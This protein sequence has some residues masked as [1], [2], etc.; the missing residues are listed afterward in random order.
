MD[1]NQL[2][3]LVAVAREKSFSRAAEALGR[4]QPAVSQAIQ[5][6]EQETGE[7]LFD[8]SSK[9]GTL[10]YAGELL[11]DYARQMLNVRNAAQNA[12]RD[13]R[14]LHSGRLTISANEHT[15]FGVLPIISELRKRHPQLKVEVQRGVASRIPKEITA[16]EV[17]L[18]VVSFKPNDPSLRSVP[19]MTDQLIL[20]VSPRN[21]LAGRRTVSITELGGEKFIAHN[22]P[23]PYRQKVIETFETHKTK[24]DIAVELPSLEAIK[25]LVEAD[26]G[27]A[28][29]PRLAA[30]DEISSGRLVGLSVN[31]MKLERKLNIVYRKSSALSHAAR[32]F[33]KIAGEMSGNGANGPGLR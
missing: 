20:I 16:R 31:E 3:V 1:I 14:D 12:L 18:G 23:S 10:T 17:E 5:R 32:E 21:P 29:V 33:L 9:D 7:I 4:T 30:V 26:G 8:R 13:M 28:L 19:I 6:L 25:K 11:L 15:V 2:E 24:L 22:A 27:V